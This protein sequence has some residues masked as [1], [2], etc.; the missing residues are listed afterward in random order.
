M[1]VPG[2]Q[3]GNGDPVRRASAVVDGV[4]YGIAL[5]SLADAAVA[6]IEL[7]SQSVVVARSIHPVTKAARS[8][9]PARSER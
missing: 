1:V 3:Q 2:W 9:R 7:P 6:E 5:A 4:L 8:S